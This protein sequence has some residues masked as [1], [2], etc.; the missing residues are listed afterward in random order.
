MRNQEPDRYEFS[1]GDR[2]RLDLFRSALLPLHRNLLASAQAEYERDHGRVEGHLEL[3]RLV[4]DEP[5]FAWL[6]AVSDLILRLDE[7]LDS[8]TL[9]LAEAIIRDGTRCFLTEDAEF[10]AFR[11]RYREA[12]QSSPDVVLAHADVLRTLRPLVE[13]RFPVERAPG[14]RF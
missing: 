4:K 3:F 2:Q 1:P 11:L 8:P 12:M 6:R 13:G 10:T 5:M 7:A 14:D 9:G